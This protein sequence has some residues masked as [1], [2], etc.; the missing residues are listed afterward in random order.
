[1]AAAVVSD[2]FEPCSHR[3]QV[4]DFPNLIL[5]TVCSRVRRSRLLAIDRKA[6]VANCGVTEYRCEEGL[7]PQGS[8]GA[9]MVLMRYNFTAPLIEAGTPVTRQPDAKVVVP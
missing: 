5:Q 3:S 6:D 9:R 8:A 1:M 7:G 4:S 2:R